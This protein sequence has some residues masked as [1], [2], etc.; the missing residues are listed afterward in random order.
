MATYREKR[1]TNTVPIVSDVPS[2][3]V[4]GEIVYFTGEGLASYNDGTWSKLTATAPPKH[5]LWRI[6]V[7]TGSD[8]NPGT[9][10][11]WYNR[12]SMNP[13]C[14]TGW[15][16]GSSPKF[17]ISTVSMNEAGYCGEFAAG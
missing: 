1:G 17:N 3:G 10:G 8:E 6:Y 2:T 15:C 11:V 4:N 13:D 16:D 5:Q 7:Q 12:W 9:Y 14:T